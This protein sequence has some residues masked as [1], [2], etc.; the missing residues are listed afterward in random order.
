MGWRVRLHR[1]TVRKRFNKKVGQT[2]VVR[3]RAQPDKYNLKAFYT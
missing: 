1:E 2:T 3:H